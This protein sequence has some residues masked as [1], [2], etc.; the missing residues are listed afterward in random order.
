MLPRATVSGTWRLRLADLN[1]TEPKMHQQQCVEQKH[2]QL[3][4]VWAAVC[5]SCYDDAQESRPFLSSLTRQAQ[6]QQSATFAGK[7]Q[8]LDKVV[9]MLP[10]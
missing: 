7:A 6:V 4:Q 9:N 8:H 3:R 10:E 1:H 5:A 2:P